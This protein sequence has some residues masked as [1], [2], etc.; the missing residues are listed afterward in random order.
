MKME[1][2]L[3]VKDYTYLEYCDYLQRKYGIGLADYMTK[4]YNINQKCKRTKEGL[5]VHHKKED[6][7]PMLCNR[8]DAKMFPFEWQSKENLVYCDYLEHLL[9][10]VLICKYPSND[11][12]ALYR[13]GI[14][15]VINFLVPELNDLYSGWKTSQPWRKNCHDKVVDDVEV[16]LE[17][18]KQF[19]ETQKDS[20]DLFEISKLLRSYNAQYGTW[21]PKNN[22]PIYNEIRILSIEVLE[23]LIE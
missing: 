11:K 13:V 4:S 18:L 23:Y 15:G 12:L 8:T 2:Y 7:A 16:Y 17:I 5:V 9:L 21:D 3:K 10:H 20:D 14:G 22:E 6:T 19:L 1:E